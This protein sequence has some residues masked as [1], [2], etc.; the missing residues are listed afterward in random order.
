M[1]TKFT[2]FMTEHGVQLRKGMEAKVQVLTM[3]FW[4]TY[5]EEQFNLPDEIAD[6]IEVF[7]KFY[8]ER[9]ANRKPQCIRSR[10]RGACP[11]DRLGFPAVRLGASCLRTVNLA[12]SRPTPN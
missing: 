11:R 1:Q 9:T 4:P 7:H 8:G 6:T 5:K 12:S 2:E 10:R 3:G